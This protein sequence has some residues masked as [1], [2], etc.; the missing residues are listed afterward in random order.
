MSDVS[1]EKIADFLRTLRDPEGQGIGHR[2]YNHYVQAFH[3]FCQWALRTKRITS[4]PI[5]GMERLN[6]EIDVRHRRRA[7]SSKEVTQLIKSARNSGKKIQQFDGE[8]RARIYFISYMTGLRRNEIA[9]LTPRSFS[10]ESSP[11]IVTVEAAFSKHRRRDVL[12]LHPELVKMLHGWLAGMDPDQKLF[13][14][15][16]R[17]RT[18]LMVKK[19]LERIGIPYETP[20]GIADFHAAGRHTHIT[21]LLKNG[22][23]LPEAKELARHSDVKMTMKYV[24]IGIK[25]QAKALSQLPWKGGKANG[26]SDQKG[27]DPPNGDQDGWECSGSDS[28]VSRRHNK[29]ASDTG[30][31]SEDTSTRDT[32][33]LRDRGCRVRSSRV[34]ST[35]KERNG[36]DSRRLH[37]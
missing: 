37:L 2:T 3:S 34:A 23:T 13:P 28:A 9:S 1:E 22:A 33:V 10:L 35:S 17:R 27:N 8:T 36:F 15:L 4:N 5:V 11:P 6:T 24:H 19:D 7:L 14:K 32:T 26:E 31:E 12:P 29:A 25:D 21:E 16:A 30:A 18:W 20:E